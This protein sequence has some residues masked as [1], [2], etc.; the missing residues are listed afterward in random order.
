MEYARG[1]SG[2]SEIT[3]IVIIMAVLSLIIIPTAFL[4]GQDGPSGAIL[5]LGLIIGTMSFLLAWVNFGVSRTSRQ[6]MARLLLVLIVSLPTIALLGI[7]N[8]SVGSP[9][10]IFTRSEQSIKSASSQGAASTIIEK[11]PKLLKTLQSIGAKGDYS[12]LALNYHQGDM[13]G[14]CGSSN[15]VACYKKDSQNNQSITVSAQPG[16][17]QLKTV[18]AHEY[19]HYAW[20]NNNLDDDKVL[21]SHLINFYAKNSDF[22]A[23]IPDHYLHNGGL[24]AGEIFS[25]ACTEMSTDRLDGYISSKCGAFIDLSK[26]AGTQSVAV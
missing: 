6:R 3:E 1:V 13:A 15:S 19:L 5:L 20:H 21:T 11:D 17:R 4:L 2:R 10:A 7:I 25:Y 8:S 24:H 14:I 9:S 23:L 22:Q 26:L 18:L 12:E 16:N